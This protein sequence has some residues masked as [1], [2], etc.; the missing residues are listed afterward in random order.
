MVTSR[1]ASRH[2]SAARGIGGK[3]R[4][5]DLTNQ[6]PAEKLIRTVILRSKQAVLSV[7][8]E[9]SRIVLRTLG[10][11]SFAAAQDDS[12]DEFF[13]SLLKHLFE[14]FAVTG[15]KAEV[16]FGWDGNLLPQIAAQV[17]SCEPNKKEGAAPAGPS[18]YTEPHAGASIR[19]P[20]AAWLL[21]ILRVLCGSLREIRR[22]IRFRKN[23]GSFAYR[24]TGAAVNAV[25]RVDVELRHPLKLGF[26]L[27][28]MN[29]VNGTNLDAFLILCTTLHNYESHESSSDQFVEFPVPRRSGAP[30]RTISDASSKSASKMNVQ[31]ARQKSCALC[32]FLSMGK[33][34]G[35]GEM[36]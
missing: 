29:A 2:S 31:F 5:K 15:V 26:I 34:A 27:S 21:I 10:A 1:S 14:R 8:K 17:G 4:H 3:V 12:T 36:D 20:S 19:R 30:A 23:G 33:A 18:G 25:Y 16:P 9:E 6:Q 7:A 11:R 35:N 32:Q 28:G 13:R 22:H 24:N